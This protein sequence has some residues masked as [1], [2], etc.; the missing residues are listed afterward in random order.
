[1]AVFYRTSPRHKRAI[2]RALQAVGE[3][4]AMT[5]KLR[6]DGLVSICAVN[7][8]FWCGWMDVYT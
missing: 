7:F 8:L 4:V 6:F 3:V 2:V 1:V 5:G